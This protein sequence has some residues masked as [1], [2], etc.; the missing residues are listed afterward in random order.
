MSRLVA[1]RAFLVVATAAALPLAEGTAQDR[2]E[3]A[4]RVDAAVVKRN[5]ARQT[6][7]AFRRDSIGTQVYPDTMTIAGGAV[8]ILTTPEFLPLVRAAAGPVDSLLR[9]RAGSAVETLR[10]TVFVVRTDSSHRAHAEVLIAQRFGTAELK[11]Q[12]TDATPARIAAVI[13]DYAQALLGNGAPTF[14]LWSRAPLPVDTATD[15][16]WS[17]VRAQLVTSLASV[18]HQCYAGNLNACKVAFGVTAEPDPVLSWYDPTTRRALVEAGHQTTLGGPTSRCLAGS[19]VDCIT[20][21]RTDDYFTVRVPPG[22]PG[23][24]S[25]LIQQAFAMGGAGA[26]QRLIAN[27]TSPSGRL[28]AASKVPFDTLLTQWLRNVRTRGNASETLT[29]AMALVA[30]GWIVVVGALSLRISR[31]R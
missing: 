7:F 5:T 20:L 2:R 27:D 15:Y 30:I 3:L 19:D 24:R 26:L 14:G 4:R 8:A 31:W 23:A 1:R 10:G 12:F 21:L 29:P 13:E 18:A 11:T 28:A 6:L 9:Y 22:S 16:N 25:T 17:T